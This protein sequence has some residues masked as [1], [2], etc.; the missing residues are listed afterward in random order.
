MKL[1]C[2]GCG[3]KFTREFIAAFTLPPIISCP[4]CGCRTAEPIGDK[5]PVRDEE[6]ELGP[7]IIRQRGNYR[8]Y[9]F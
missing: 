1:R 5:E 9:S 3:H 8:L 7:R 6:P 4:N 2:L